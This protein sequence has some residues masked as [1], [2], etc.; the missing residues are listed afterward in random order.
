MLKPEEE[1][2]GKVTR[3]QRIR[4]KLLE[5]IDNEEISEESLPKRLRKAGM[6]SRN[7]GLYQF[8]LGECEPGIE[9]FH[10]AIR[11]YRDSIR[12]FRAQRDSPSEN[13]EG[14]ITLLD[15][16]YCTL[17]SGDVDLTAN[18]AETV[19]ATEKDHYERFST[20]WRYHYTM[21]LAASILDTGE[22]NRY[23]SELEKL[24]PD[25][26]KSHEVFF[27]ALWMVI[28]GIENRN[29]NRFYTGFD[30]LLEWHEGEKIDLENKTS[31]DDLV[32]KQAAAL[33][34]LANRKAIDVHVDSPYI[35]DCVYELA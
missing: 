32:C 29:K 12:E 35:P 2:R 3:Y 5:P 31:A 11:L 9:E 8:T 33:I 7:L 24:I 20:E 15:Y 25:G 6:V 27:T 14:E 1:I 4:K 18:A 30:R 19:L 10:T 22:Q 17:F 23:L 16:L 13:F 28:S 21:A 26:D 34:V